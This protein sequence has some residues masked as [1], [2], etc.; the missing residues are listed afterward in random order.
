MDS[1]YF[2]PFLALAVLFAAA[3]LAAASAYCWRAVKCSAP[4]A[5]PS[6]AEA[7][8]IHPVAASAGDPAQLYEVHVTVRHDQ[9]V[10]ANNYSLFIR[11]CA[12][13]AK[14]HGDAISCKPILIDDMLATPGQADE[15]KLERQP[16]CSMFCNGTKDNAFALGE[17]FAGAFLRKRGFAPVRN[18]VEARFKN[19][20]ARAGSRVCERP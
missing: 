17:A 8:E 3:A 4:S 7:A 14:V 16:M 15:V 12:D 1:S 5:S 11:S 13:F 9:Y 19:V 18:K 20:A 6:G 2:F 10:A